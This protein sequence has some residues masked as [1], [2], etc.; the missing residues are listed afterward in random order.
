MTESRIVY[1]L[2]SIVSK[3]EGYQ[4]LIIRVLHRHAVRA[5]S[6]ACKVVLIA[7]TAISR[8]GDA[9]G[10]RRELV[11]IERID[12]MV[13]GHS[14]SERRENRIETNDE[15]AVAEEFVGVSGLGRTEGARLNAPLT[16]APSTFLCPTLG[17]KQRN[18]EGEKREYTLRHGRLSFCVS[19]CDPQG[20]SQA[21]TR[22]VQVPL[23]LG[24][25]QR[26]ICVLVVLLGGFLKLGTAAG[27][28]NYGVIFPDRCSATALG[29][30]RSAFV[31]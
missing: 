7:L 23:L 15:T 4:P 20:D 26:T 19:S 9:H 10:S 28:R 22:S 13:H 2:Q 8:V 5:A 11:G 29:A 24:T 1:C 31:N 16:K 21:R 17:T 27:G 30:L 14:K 18:P 12:R 6:I 3:R 25:C